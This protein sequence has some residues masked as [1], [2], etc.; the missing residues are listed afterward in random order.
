MEFNSHWETLALSLAVDVA[1]TAGG[2]AGEG[3]SPLWVNG[4]GDRGWGS[5][6]GGRRAL[7]FGSLWGSGDHGGHSEGNDGSGELHF[8]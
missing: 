8:D 7:G 1:G 6:D 2:D 5:G 3:A 4:D